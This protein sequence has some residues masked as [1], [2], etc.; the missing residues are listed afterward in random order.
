MLIDMSEIPIECPNMIEYD[1]IVDI[2]ESWVEASY[3]NTKYTCY[4]VIPSSQ[5]RPKIMLKLKS[6]EIVSM[7][8]NIG[9][10]VLFEKDCMWYNQTH[11]TPC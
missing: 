6:G 8:F 9:G 4:A 7:C 5:T 11:H 1:E 2:N 3:P 10:M